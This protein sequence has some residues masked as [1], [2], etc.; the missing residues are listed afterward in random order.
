MDKLIRALAEAGLD[1]SVVA[2]IPRDA[3]PTFPP[4][5]GVTVTRVPF[6][7]APKSVFKR[8]LNAVLFGSRAEGAS[9]A[10]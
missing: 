2:G 3:T 8:R 1:V 10:L 6:D 4:P 7:P 9:A 5:S